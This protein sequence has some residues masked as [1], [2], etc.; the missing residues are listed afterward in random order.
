MIKEYENC[1]KVMQICRYNGLKPRRLGDYSNRIKCTIPEEILRNLELHKKIIK[2]LK[3]FI[4]KM[5]EEQ[6]VTTDKV[7]LVIQTKKH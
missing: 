2:K 5:E 3:P 7:F 1:I 4:Y 6:D